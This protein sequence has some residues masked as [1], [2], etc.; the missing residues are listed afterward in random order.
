MQLLIFIGD[1]LNEMRACESITS[2]LRARVQGRKLERRRG[3]KTEN[4]RAQQDGSL[5]TKIVSDRSY[6]P[7]TMIM[8]IAKID[9]TIDH[10]GTKIVKKNMM[11]GGATIGQVVVTARG[12]F[13]WTPNI[14]AAVAIRTSTGHPAPIETAARNIAEDIVRSH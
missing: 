9:D 4:D 10:R 1:R 8:M 14:A 7:T 11:S 3:R 5:G 6:L 12:V 2:H 13:Q